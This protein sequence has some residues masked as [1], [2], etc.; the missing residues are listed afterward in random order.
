MIAFVIGEREEKR[1]KVGATKFRKLLAGIPSANT[2]YCH[3]SDYNLAW[4]KWRHGDKGSQKVQHNFKE[5][6][7]GVTRRG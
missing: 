6:V 5:V 2:K 7:G 1:R 3:C 4:L